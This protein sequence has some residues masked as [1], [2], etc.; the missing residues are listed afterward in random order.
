MKIPLALVPAE[1]LQ[2]SLRLPLKAMA[3]LSGVIGEQ[4]GEVRADVTIKNREGNVELQGRL[5]ATLRPP[6]QRCLEPVTLVI[7]EPMRVALVSGQS[8]DDAPEEAHLTQGDL[9][10]SYYEG[11]A[12]DLSHILEDEL[13]LLLPEPV[14]DEDEEGRCVVCGKRTDE[15]L[16]EEGDASPAHPF[17][18]LKIL[19]NNE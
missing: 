7:D 18:Q 10:L 5:Q 15:L 3:R 8:Y 4:S 19:L 6:C 13:L 17:A 1:G 11:E 14:A 2:R 16:P 12:L 9:E